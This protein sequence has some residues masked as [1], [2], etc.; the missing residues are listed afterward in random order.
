MPVCWRTDGIL[1]AAV[2]THIKV[3]WGP[4][5]RSGTVRIK[6]Q[7]QQHLKWQVSITWEQQYLIKIIYRHSRGRETEIKSITV[8][9]LQKI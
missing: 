2:R 7:Y 6:T 8:S 9:R 4:T 3:M 1:L 5:K